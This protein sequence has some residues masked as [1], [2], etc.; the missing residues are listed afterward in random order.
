M[1]CEVRQILCLSNVHLRGCHIG[2]WPSSLEIS[3]FRTENNT[4]SCFH[5]TVSHVSVK[6][7]A[8]PE[9]EDSIGS[10]CPDIAVTVDRGTVSNTVA[11][12]VLIVTPR[13]IVEV[14][15]L[16]YSW[17]FMPDDILLAKSFIGF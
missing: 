16:S 9:L 4:E 2:T 15:I 1:G 7:G 11:I 14:I 5:V 10:L 6:N 13:A 3:T 8:N 12:L 17:E